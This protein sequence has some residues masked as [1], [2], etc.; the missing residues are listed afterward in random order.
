MTPTEIL[1]VLSTL[2]A[3]LLAVQAQKWLERFRENQEQKLRVFKTLMSTRADIVSSAHVQALNMIDLEFQG[4]KFKP[5]R[6]EWKTYL[7]HLS[8]CPKG[9]E[10]LQVLWGDKRVDLLVRLLIEMGKSLGYEFDE[11]HVKKGIYAPEAHSQ[12]DNEKMLL[13]RGL[14]RLID[15]DWH[16]KMD[17]TNL[18]ITTQSAEQEQQLLRQHLIELLNGDRSLNV[19]TSLHAEEKSA[20]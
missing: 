2:V 15:S 17:I 1:I 14:L 6:T 20:A 18:P 8:S 10:N 12:I 19:A 7:D 9:D 3:P 13:R 5:V 4:D 11:V 16:L